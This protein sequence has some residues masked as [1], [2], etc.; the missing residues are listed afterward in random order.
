MLRKLVQR[1]TRTSVF[2]QVVQFK[3][4]KIADQQVPGEL[5][6]LQP[7]EIVQS[8][9]LASPEILSRALL[10]DYEDPFPE[11]VDESPIVAQQLHGFLETCDA[12][13]VNAEDFEK[14]VVKGVRLALFV[15]G[16]PPLVREARGASLDLVRAETHE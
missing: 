1:K 7:R 11:Q 9:S 3:D 14:L 13:S 12:P 2:L 15:V 10:L 16:V 8:L 6:F 5:V 4:L